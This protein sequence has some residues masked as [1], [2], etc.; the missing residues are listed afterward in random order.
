MNEDIYVQTMN[1]RIILMNKYFSTENIYFFRNTVQ[2][3][4][5]IHV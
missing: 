5:L 4:I 2:M 1:I 3:H